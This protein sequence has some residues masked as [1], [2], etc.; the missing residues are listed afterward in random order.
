MIV[1]W[2]E[3]I[4][5]FNW[6]SIEPIS[7][8]IKYNEFQHVNQ[9]RLLSSHQNLEF[10]CLVWR[11]LLAPTFV[12]NKKDH[13]HY[14]VHGMETKYKGNE[15]IFDQV[16]YGERF[17][18]IIL[19]WNRIFSRLTYTIKGNQYIQFCIYI[20]IFNIYIFNIFLISFLS[21]FSVFFFI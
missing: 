15:E 20:Y 19:S 18:S 4:S 10:S 7:E 16:G 21:V 5:E 8:T 6:L 13:R 17:A 12:F 1:L 2:Y 9:A 11:I 3:L 14:V